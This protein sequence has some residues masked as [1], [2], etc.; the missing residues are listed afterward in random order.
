[1]P[2][3]IYV[4]TNDDSQCRQYLSVVQRALFNL[5]ELAISSVNSQ[6]H[7]QSQNMIRQ[8][9]IFLAIYGSD[10]DTVPTGE[11]ASHIELEYQFATAAEKPMILFM[12][13]DARDT[14]DE[15][16]KA[17]LEYLMQQHV[18]NSFT[19]EVDLEAK[20][21]VAIDNYSRTKNLRRLLPTKLKFL[22]QKS[23]PAPPFS[24]DEEKPASDISDEA[25]QNLVDRALGMSQDDL[26]K[27]VRRALE[28]HDATLQQKETQII[29]NYDNK[30]TVCPLW[31]EPIRRSQFDSDIFMIM[32]FREQYTA[33]YT[34][35][36]QSVTAQL[37]LTI[38]RGDDFFSTSGS[39]MQEV[40]AALYACRLVIVETS[41]INA[42]VYY[43][44]GIAHTL[45]KPAIL[46]TQ[47]KEVKE[48]PF[49]LRHLRFIVYEDSIEG[50]VKL[51]KHLRQSIIWL[52]NDLEEGEK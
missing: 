23:P 20:V 21:K 30:I 48:L 15:R 47:T 9:D 19:D 33:L 11:T 16:Q 36:I 41:E 39:I 32:P 37:N 3:K 26:E 51:E 40:W 17:F 25:L 13:A 6:N 45:G 35:V 44:L 10:Y 1:M 38:K 46:L 43:E 28:I 7:A 24:R 4:S 50:S 42:N 52:L 31:G 18:I 5:N 49:D 29:E 8:S 34:N 22:E 12:M 14:E 2:H 27:I